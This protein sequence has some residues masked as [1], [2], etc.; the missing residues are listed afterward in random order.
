M[1][2]SINAPNAN[3]AL[4]RSIFLCLLIK[5][6]LLYEYINFKCSQLICSSVR[7]FSSY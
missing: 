7:L 6:I 4:D 5:Y 2:N 3:G 1:Y